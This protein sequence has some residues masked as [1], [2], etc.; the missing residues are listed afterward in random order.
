MAY[1]ALTS[2]L[3][4]LTVSP[5]GERCCG[6]RGYQ[7]GAHALLGMLGDTPIFDT[8]STDPGSLIDP[9]VFDQPSPIID[10]TPPIETLPPI[11]DATALPLPNQLSPSVYSSYPASV[12]T[13]FTSNGD[14]TYT[15]IQTGQTVPYQIAEQLTAAT[16]GAA[17]SSLDTTATGQNLTI[18]DASGATSSVNTNNL[19]VAAQ[20]LQAAGQLVNAAG[21]LTAQGQALLNGGNL[22]KPAPVSANPF[23]GAMASLTSWFSGSTGGFPNVAI[24]GVGL[25]AVFVLPSLMGGKKRRR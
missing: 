8:S 1:S 7:P 12:G 24:L 2:P 21:K 25:A 13:E 19:T 22:Y 17:T 18:T 11:I 14:G 15:N 3:P 23:S 5:T 10:L 4:G 20:A 9:S 16:T 6:L